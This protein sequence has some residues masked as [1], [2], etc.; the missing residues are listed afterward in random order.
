MS[1]TTVGTPA[2]HA[3]HQLGQT[4]PSRKS[5]LEELDST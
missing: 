5:L 4:H 1:D 3:S 2:V